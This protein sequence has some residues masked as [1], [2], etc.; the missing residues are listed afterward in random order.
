MGAISTK[1]A[2]ERKLER[3]ETE[4]NREAFEAFYHV[5]QKL[6]DIKDNRRYESA[7]FNSWGAY[8]ASGRIDYRRRHADIV[9]RCAE[10][11][12]KLGANGAHDWT[13]RQVRELC[14]CE[15]DNDAKR[16]AKAAIR[17]AKKSGERVTAKLIARV[18]DQDTGQDVR[19]FA[20]ASLDKHLD[21][22]ASILVR[23]HTSLGQIADEQWE[24]VDSEILARV[25][26][27]SSALNK[28]LRS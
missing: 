27:E 10:L 2:A 25:R 14:K 16:V 28:F 1:T 21:K 3:L 19:E 12:P 23:W 20:A 13:V 8:C 11:R 9:I 6:L 7:G 24:E 4:I 22:L 17:Q 18:R 15:N 26:N 5:G